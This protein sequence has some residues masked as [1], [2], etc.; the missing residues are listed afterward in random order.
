M[1]YIRFE[2]VDKFYGKT[3]V[4]KNINLNIEQGELVTLLGL[5]GCG[6]STLLRAL[7]GL[8]SVSAGKIWL[9]GTDVTQM[10]PR[11]RKIGMVFQQYSLFPNMTAEQNIAFGLKVAGESKAAIKERVDEMVDIVGLTEQRSKYPAQ[12]SGGQQQRVALARALVMQPRVLL[13]DEPLSAIDALLRRQLQLEIRRLHDK[14]HMTTLF[15]T[16]DQDEAMIMSDTI[17]L[18]NGG[19]IEQSGT[20]TQVYTHPA[21]PFVANFMGHYNFLTSEQL[22][23]AAGALVK[24]ESGAVRPEV[25]AVS[26]QA[27]DADYTMEGHV[28]RCLLHGAVLRYDVDCGG[29][30]M[31][32]DVLYNGV[33]PY[34]KGTKVHLSFAKE[35]LLLY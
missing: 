5:S 21:T 1:A 10:P 4:L 20:P 8:E 26:D 14:L 23:A 13:L 12:M 16:H 35:N 18:M 29:V 32:A 9:A 22:K 28:L 15:V 6:K 27:V 33:E 11:D 30:T 3:Q 17:H 25:I 34:A 2:N 19:C 24:C 7:A 31:Q